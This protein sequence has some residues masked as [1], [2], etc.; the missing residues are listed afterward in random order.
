LPV[1]FGYRQAIDLQRATAVFATNG[2]ACHHVGDHLPAILGD[3]EAVAASLRKKQL[4][5]LPPGGRAQR[6]DDVQ[7]VL[8]H[9][10]H[11]CWPGAGEDGDPVA[12]LPAVL[13]GRLGGPGQV[14]GEHGAVLGD[15]V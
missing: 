10:T 14:F 13:G 3:Y 12:L 9:L 11:R 5:E 6:S 7:I 4:L 2:Y 15:A 1:A 8:C